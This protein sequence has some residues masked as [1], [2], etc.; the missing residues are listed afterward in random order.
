MSASSVVAALAAGFSGAIVPDI[1]ATFG[2][3]LH[4]LQVEA[5]PNGDAELDALAAGL[6]QL[7]ILSLAGNDDA[8]T[9]EAWRR[10]LLVLLGRLEV[11]ELRSASDNTFHG[12][13]RL[14]GILKRPPRHR[15]HAWR[16]CQLSR[17]ARWA[18]AVWMGTPRRLSPPWVDTPRSQLLPVAV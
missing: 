4:T 2:T 15:S 10:N 7:R 1:D 13:N 9:V 6:P 8:V 11:L 18:S 14:V 3:A 17:C 16:T 12:L 5:G